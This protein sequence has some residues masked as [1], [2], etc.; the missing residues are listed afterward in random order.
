MKFRNMTLLR[1]TLI[2]IGLMFL[3][4]IIVVFFIARTMLLDDFAE[5]EDSA[6][7]QNTERAMNVINAKLDTLE[8]ITN[9]WAAWDD[10]YDFIA[11]ANEDYI[12]TNLTDETFTTLELNLI[13]FIDIS[14]NI[15]YEKAFDLEKESET[16]TSDALYE[17]I[18]PN[19][20]LLNHKGDT[21]SS[22]K[23]VMLLSEEPLL[24]A[25]Q[26]ILT[27][28]D[29]GPILGTLIMGRYLDDT[30][31]QEMSELADLSLAIYPSDGTQ[32]PTDF[33]EASNSLSDE[34][35][36]YVK[37][38][39]SES[40]A[41]YALIQDIYGNPGII[42]RTDMPRDIYNQG[43]STVNF[44]IIFMLSLG[45]CCVVFVLFM[46]QKTVLS[47]MSRLSS[48]VNSISKSGDMSARISAP[49]RDEL[50]IL[51]NNIN[52]M[53]SAL[54]D[55][56]G[57]LKSSEERFRALIENAF[58]VVLIMKAD[59]TIIYVSPPIQ[60]VLEYKPVEWI[61]NKSYDYIHPEDSQ[62]ILGA[63]QGF[64]NRH[65]TED[66]EL[67][68]RHKDGS[69]RDVEAVVINL[70]DHVAVEGIVINFHD[71]TEHKRAEEELSKVEQLYR[72]TIDSAPDV[73]INIDANG[74]LALANQYAVERTGIPLDYS[75]GRSFLE[76]VA[77]QSLPLA[78]QI[79][80]KAAM[81]EAVK[82]VEIT[83]KAKDGEE[84]LFEVNSVPHIVDGEFLGG[85]AILRDLSERK[86]AE[87]ILRESEEKLRLIFESVPEGIIV[88]DLDGKILDVNESV[89]HMHG[90]NSKEEI[91][92]QS[93]FEFIPERNHAETKKDIKRFFKSGDTGV[94]QHTRTLVKKDGSEF[95]AAASVAI[96]RDVD[97]QTKG[98]VAVTTDIT[99]Q[100][101]MQ[102]QLI[103][104][105][106]LASIGQLAAGIAHEINN[107][108]TS[109]VGFS[110]LLLERDFPDDI[111]EN[112][113]IINTDAKRI[114]NVVKGLLISV[115]KQGTEKASEDINDIIQEVLQLRSYEQKVTNIK[116]ET[117]LAPDLPLAFV[118]GAQMGQV[119]MNLLV[120]AEQ[121]MLE[122]NERGN[123]KIKTEKVG[124]IIRITITDDGPGISPDDM[125]NL[126]S[127]FFTT[128]EVGKGTG[129][130]LS[131][132]RGI[133]T[134]HDGKIYAESELG[135]GASFII[136]LP[137]P[138]ANDN[139]SNNYL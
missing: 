120:N 94:I 20:D 72:N 73:I 137:I 99:E 53:L 59:G 28:E 18:D 32:L 90:Y 4:V 49:G 13:M 135:K 17:H 26:P 113:E 23:G 71:V 75:I 44:L 5:M 54:Q 9:D 51:A 115:R 96:L 105:D 104:T 109:V 67:R 95:P 43:Q 139:E 12:E 11:D 45:I 88:S 52:D 2:I 123:L 10:S 55:S 74:N 93:C 41:G 57:K 58:D 122:A 21:T 103:L 69:W 81:G 38:L 119:F 112:L 110:D 19:D 78:M 60:R 128:K 87:V 8:Q 116:V 102:E 101:K 108:L 39:D 86:Q 40:V 92:G 97:G 33:Q 134:D 48:G 27:S 76:F 29:Q 34:A 7:R 89:V 130:G 83:L 25:S 91:I 79:F 1:K 63:V 30:L 62:K 70:L 111:R 107:P 84:I 6:T 80:E 136:E 127:P 100:Q 133:I 47:R 132:C 65:F 15:I 129:L 117:E 114:A 66:V 61:G 126:F 3:S 98:F 24:F 35:Q 68:L 124:D 121:A 46:L 22:I 56:Q 138:A 64:Q 106:K 50:S 36:I 14:G 118:N 31:L 131:I 37:E 77:P 82:G 125:K 85:V 42:L 16:T